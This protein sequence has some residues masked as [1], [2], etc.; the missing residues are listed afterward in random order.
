MSKKL[1]FVLLLCITL[2]YTS[3]IVA[4]FVV[5]NIPG[6][7]REISVYDQLVEFSASGPTETFSTDGRMDINTATVADLVQLPGIGNTLAERIVQ[8]RTEHGNYS[9]IDDLLKVSG[10]GEGKLNGIAEYITVGG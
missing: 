7:E 2:I 1:S 5:R 6:R 4:F 3:V 9:S 10:I 8:Y